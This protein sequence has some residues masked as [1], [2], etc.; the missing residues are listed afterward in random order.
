MT[1]YKLSRA[2]A[3]DLRTIS[4]YTVQS[5]GVKQAKIY[6][7][8]FEQCLLTLSENP[9]IGRDVSHIRPSLRRFEH[10][11][12]L[13]YYLLRDNGLYIVRVLHNRQN[14]LKHL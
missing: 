12:H 10:E 11:S 1:F 7:D 8:G 5:F 2:A 4:Q 3:K 14:P 13:I 9:F 6:G